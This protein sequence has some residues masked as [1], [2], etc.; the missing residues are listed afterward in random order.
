[1]VDHIRAL[2]DAP[3]YV[4]ASDDLG[5]SQVALQ[6]DHINSAITIVEV[7]PFSLSP[8]VSTLFHQLFSG[9]AT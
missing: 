4:A 8:G 2:C 3:D 5:E 6:Q 9:P 7:I 1:M